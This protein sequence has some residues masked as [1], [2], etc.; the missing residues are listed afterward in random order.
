MKNIH[1]LKKPF[2][3][4]CATAL[5]LTAS[6]GIAPSVVS[7]EETTTGTG[8]NRYDLWDGPN[9][10]D[11]TTVEYAGGDGSESNPYLI[12]T[13]DQLYKLVMNNNN[14][15]ASE[16]ANKY[17]RLEND[18]YLNDVSAENWYEASDLNEWVTLSDHIGQFGGHF[19]GNGYVV[20]GIYYKDTTSEYAALFPKL[21]PYDDVANVTVKNVGVEDSYIQ[22]K[23]AGAITAVVDGYRDGN[24]TV[25]ISCCYADES[26][27][28][29]GTEANGFVAFLFNYYFTMENCASRVRMI[30][31]P[32]TSEPRGSLLGAMFLIDGENGATNVDNA[33]K[34]TIKNCYAV[35][36]KEDRDNGFT[37]VPQS[38]TGR[39]IRYENVHAGV[40]PDGNGNS[41]A[42]GADFVLN[43]QVS[44]IFT[45]WPSDFR[46]T[47]LLAGFSDDVWYMGYG[48]EYWIPKVFVKSNV[49]NGSSNLNVGLVE[50]AGG[51]GTEAN[52][53]LIKNGN[54]LYKAATEGESKYFRL[55]NDIY[56]NDVSAENWYETSGLNEWI[57]TGSVFGGHFDG[58]GYVVHGIYYK[59]TSSEMAALFPKL[60]AYDDARSVTVKNVGVEDSYIQGKYAGAI[61]AVVDGNRDG[62]HNVEISCCYADE[63]V[64]LN[65]T[66]ANG[67]VAFLFNYYFTMDNCASR[68][69]MIGTPN[70]D[71]PRG[72][73]LGAMFLSDDSASGGLNNIEKANKIT[74]KN[75]YAVIQK[76]DRD[77][78]F[79]AVPQSWTGRHIRY[80]NVHA[81]V[82]PNDSGNSIV[83]SLTLNNQSDCVFKHWPSDFRAS[84]LISSFSREIWLAGDGADRYMIPKVFVT[85][86]YGDTNRDLSI[87]IR[88]LVYL[89]KVIS[90]FEGVSNNNSDLNGDG[91]YDAADLILLRTKLLNG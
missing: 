54:Q 56:L 80:E 52:P 3:M 66:E 12:K 72:S 91:N 2:S 17:Y 32:S 31:T 23:Y 81:G 15:A 33:K 18:I 53:Y 49:W 85:F 47:T 43:N 38:W 77:N 24:H 50:Y 20:H 48:G 64:Y 27:Y 37:A 60:S 35:I 13:A 86:E 29:N 88:D 90:K 69:R 57:T 11:V 26:V 25:N 4:L 30:G 19:D 6:L 22:G 63:S 71:E 70:A 84:S 28:L 68:I 7:A 62:N 39:H 21:G 42:E 89:K 46:K 76:E 61:T 14:T 83:E 45:R 75:C 58:N 9:G 1:W 65:G 67:F 10:L 44:C 51:D 59:D 55:E 40:N 34:I 73:L 82:Y 36:Q 41:I 5:V 16:S 74:I 78:G 8:S 87:D 79:T